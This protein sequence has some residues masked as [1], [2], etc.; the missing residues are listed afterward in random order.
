MG[1][2]ADHLGGDGLDHP[3]EIEQPAF[4]RHLTRNQMYSA[5]PSKR[6]RRPQ[7][8]GFF[9]RG[10]LADALVHA[11]NDARQIGFGMMAIL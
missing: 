9:R 1:M 10:L 6:R 3:A 7:Q 8:T 5:A 4:A 11:V 2:A